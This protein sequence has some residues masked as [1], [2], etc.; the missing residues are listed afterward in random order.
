M[1]SKKNI[2]NFLLV[3]IGIILVGCAPSAENIKMVPYVDYSTYTSSGRTIKITQV[4]DRGEETLGISRI[5]NESFQE[6]LHMTLRRSK[7]FKGVYTNKV[8]DYELHTEIVSQ[9]VE[10]GISAYAA[11]YVH[12]SLVRTSTRKIIWSENIF[13]QNNAFGSNQGKDILE[14]VARDNLA[15]LI[16]KLRK[17]LGR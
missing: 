13:S 8:A 6:A 11:L 1:K 17:I 16:R 14:S 9:K 7:L 2:K 12:Y 4:K 10:P 15:Q 5:D 3:F